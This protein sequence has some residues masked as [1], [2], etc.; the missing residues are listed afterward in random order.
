ML[1]R[2]GS[3]FTRPVL[4]PTLPIRNFGILPEFKLSDQAKRLLVSDIDGFIDHSVKLKS[5]DHLSDIREISKLRKEIGSEYNV[6][7]VD[8]VRSQFIFKKWKY[9]SEAGINFMQN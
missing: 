2:L 5:P 1:R 8:W 9:K 7:Y 4:R 3:R 6:N